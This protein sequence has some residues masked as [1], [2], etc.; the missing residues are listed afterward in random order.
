MRCVNHPEIETNLRCGKCGQPIC[1]KCMV[2]TPVGARCPKCAKL[3]QLPTYRVSTIFYFRAIVT[4]LGVA[5]ITGIIWGAISIF[6]PFF[7]LNLVLAAG[8]GYAIG[9]ITGLSVNRKRG[10]GLAAIAGI[11]VII[12]YLVNILI[13]GGLPFNL[14]HIIFDL[15]ALGLGIYVAANRLL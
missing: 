10:R 4:A 12:S 7:Y 3:Y 11:A 8:T 5:V 15:V 6:I 2:T 1:P 9:E 14:L 13:F